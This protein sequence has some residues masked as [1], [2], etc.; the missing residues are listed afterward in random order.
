VD[1]GL[2]VLRGREMARAGCPLVATGGGKTRFRV[3]GKRLVFH[4]QERVV[5]I[6]FNQS[7]TDLTQPLSPRPLRIWTVSSVTCS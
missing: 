5:P 7:R 2:K 6:T 1:V 4:S 3:V